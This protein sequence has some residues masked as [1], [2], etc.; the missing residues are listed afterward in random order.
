MQCFSKPYIWLTAN[1][2]FSCNASSPS[3]NSL[4]PSSL[5]TAL[6]ITSNASWNIS[7]HLTYNDLF[8]GSCNYITSQPITLSLTAFLVHLIDM[9]MRWDLYSKRPKHGILSLW[10][11]LQ[12]HETKSNILSYITSHLRITSIFFKTEQIPT[13]TSSFINCP[14]CT[15]PC[16]NST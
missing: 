8:D 13:S 4:L 6:S 12:L 11:V 7:L 10:N 16:R 14:T 15:K 2:I 9:Y 3:T 1:L 5:I